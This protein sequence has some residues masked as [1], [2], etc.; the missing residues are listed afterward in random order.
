LRNVD[1][2]SLMNLQVDVERVLLAHKAVRAE[3][4]AERSQ[5]GHWT[6]HVASSPLA[7]AAAIS[8]L[9]A[10]HRPDTTHALRHNTEGD[11]QVIAQ[12]VQGDLSELLVECLH[13]LARHQ[14]A[15]GGWGDCDTS[16]SNIAATMLVQ[17][18]FRLTG[19][20][21]K[22]SDLMLRS[23]DYVEA[24]GGVAGLRR[25]LGRDKSLLAAVLANCALAGMV[26]WRQVPALPFE[27]VC[28]P[29]RLQ[30]Y[31]QPPVARH[32]LPVLLAV[33]RAKYHYDPPRNPLTRLVRRS[34]CARGLANLEQYQ[35]ADDSFSSCVATTA[36]VVMSLA[37]IGCQEHAIVQRGVEFLLSSVRGDA[38]W[39][40]EM[41]LAVTVTALAMDTLATEHDLASTSVRLE[42]HPADQRTWSELNRASWETAAAAETVT[43]HLANG[44]IK[45]SNLPANDERPDDGLPLRRS[46]DWLL[47]SQ[48]AG[49]HLP[50]DVSPG[51]WAAGDSPGALPNTADTARALIAL[52]G[53]VD[54]HEMLQSERLLRSARL[55]IAW[56]LVRQNDDGGWANYYHDDSSMPFYESAADVTAHALQALAA[57]RHIEKNAAPAIDRGWRYLETAQ[58]QDGSFVPVLFGNEIQPGERNP[59]YGTAQVL[60]A[61]AMLGQLESDVMGRAVRWLLSAQH[62]GGGWGP[63]RAPLDYSGA[64]PDGF[65]AWRANQ[66][67]AKL[68]SV[69]ETGL[70]VTAL[71]PLADS[72]ESCSKAV[73][74]GLKWLVN[75]VEQDAHRRPAVIGFSVTGLWYHERLY[76]LVFAAEALSRA[77]PRL[78]S[79]RPVAA[80][81]V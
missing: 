41:D 69:E 3:L 15:D 39:P 19:V 10:A 67:M 72:S 12:L 38:S 61:A 17:A 49:R 9:V 44:E 18:A 30:R 20:P 31:V 70:A 29:K 57:W 56:L 43:D 64:E 55:G 78:A 79:Q 4:M 33:G 7:T 73:S 35:S 40:I 77:E 27:L 28:L 58:R 37:S 76:P 50:A 1:C 54:R 42:R 32:A 25:R 5:R 13:W 81:V 59:V 2:V 14:N 60:I 52:A 48:R 22:Y 8:A 26:P 23:D 21:A 66:S 71:L 11:S 16:H 53:W 51:G 65:R 63:P 75:A 34:L 74:E 47:E 80:P 62:S 36:F 45:Q 46:L 24:Q 68:C 6:G